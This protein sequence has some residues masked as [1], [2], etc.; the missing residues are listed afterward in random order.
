MRK[1][2]VLGLTA[3]VACNQPRITYTEQAQKQATKI[4]EM[5]WHRHT[6]LIGCLSTSGDTVKKIDLPQYQAVTPFS[7][8]IPPG[9]CVPPL[10]NGT[11]HTHI[12]YDLKGNPDSLFSPVDLESQV[13][14]NDAYKTKGLFCVMYAYN[15][16]LCKNDKEQ[17]VVNIKGEE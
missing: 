1:E 11:L 13:T 7:A 10:H 16:M 9:T 15:R 3:L 12:L 17:N 5:S 6:E 4:Y 14:Y 2:L 8:A